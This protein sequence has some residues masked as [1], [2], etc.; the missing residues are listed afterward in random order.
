MTMLSMVA[1]HAVG[2]GQVDAVFAVLKQANDAIE[3]Y[4]KNKVVNA[5]IGAVFNEDETFATLNSVEEHL[6]KMPAAEL[7][8]YAPIAGLPEYLDAV[9]DFTFLGYQ[10]KNTYAK[11][12]GTP[13][14]TGAIRHVFNNYL[15]Q[16]QKAL[17]PDWAWGNY[18]T[19]ANEHQRE[20]D[21]YQ[22][23]DENYVFN[24]AS[25]KEK[26]QEL[27]KEQDNLV[28]VFN[29]PAHNPTGYSMTD[30]DWDAIIP[31]MMNCAD[32]KSKKITVLLD[33]AY[34]DYAGTPQETRSFLKKFEGL[35][36]N[37]L[38]TL[39]YS[40]SK[41]FM[42]YGMRSGGL[43]GLSAS[44][45]IAEE[46][47]DINSASCRGVWSNCNRGAQKLLADIYKD[48][49]LKSLVDAE[50]NKYTKLVQERADI[51][52][53]EAQEVGLT[54]AP[55]NSGFFISVPTVNPK[56]LS[57]KLMEDNI[58]AVPLKKGVRFALCS[59]PLAKIPGLASK[60]KNA[61]DALK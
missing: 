57:D 39:G 38:V 49:A 4:G 11:A 35:P 15:E 54:I 19:L 22:L 7:M 40:M 10:P 21:T 37:M 1:P 53:N 8:N 12:I 27:L 16:G 31:F 24:A 9:I 47:F 36:E 61:L 59:V 28:I 26:V 14:G 44:E 50:R 25:L 43:V 29:T 46:F 30:E 5:T 60:T 56:G 33:I 51:Y 42:V 23:F 2:K 55:F 3:I 13:G 20:I 18:K 17:I 34:I 45:E 41:S 58:F 6:R 52:K 32:D 48:Q